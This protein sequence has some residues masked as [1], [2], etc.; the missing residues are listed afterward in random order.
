MGIFSRVQ[1]SA[2]EVKPEHKGS[3]RYRRYRTAGED[4]EISWLD[5]RGKM[6]SMRAKVVNISENGI[7]FRV[8]EAVMPVLVRFRANRVGINGVG[9][10]RYCYRAGFKFIVGLEF[11]LDLHWQPPKGEV[12]EPI[13]LCGS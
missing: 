8:P 12:Q 5:T 13:P 2:P 7:A 10:V 6:K 1:P 4:L 3:R 11:G 9:S